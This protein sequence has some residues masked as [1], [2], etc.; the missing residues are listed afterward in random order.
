[1]C[2]D[3][4]SGTSSGKLRDDPVGPEGTLSINQVDFVPTFSLLMGIPIPFSNLGKVIKDVIVSAAVKHIQY[5]KVNVEQ[6]F[7]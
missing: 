1:M 7:R 5:M 3:F 6:V 2:N 4:S